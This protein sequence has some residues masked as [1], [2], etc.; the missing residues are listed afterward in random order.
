MSYF[1]DTNMCI[2]FLKGTY[3]VLL[4]KILSLHPSEIIIPAVV[5]AELIYGAEK[6]LKRDENIRKITAFLLPFEI[7]PFGDSA[8]FHYG[9]IRTSLEKSGMLIGPNDL[10]IAATVLAENGILVTNNIKEFSRIPG[11]RLEN[12]IE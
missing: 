1:L 10:F 9:K 3:P 11:L 4:P 8:T 5:K 12:W 7:A 2:Y 6:S